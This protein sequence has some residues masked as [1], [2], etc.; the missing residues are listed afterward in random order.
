MNATLSGT[1]RR[2]LING[3]MILTLGLAAGLTIPFAANAR[4]VLA[5]HVIGITCGLAAIAVALTLPF[6][7]LSRRSEQVV[8]WTLLISLYLGFLTQWV[9]GMLKLSRMFI[10]TAA[11]QPEGSQGLE[12]I[13]EYINKAISPL[14]LLPFLL[15]ILGLARAYRSERI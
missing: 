14:T 7:G 13:I 10:V 9:G 4:T 5:A 6:A 2:L 12:T 3:A 1:S 8:E 15:L 11:G